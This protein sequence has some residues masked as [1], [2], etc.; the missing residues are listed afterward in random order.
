MDPNV[1]E[2][3]K[4]REEEDEEINDADNDEEN[5]EADGFEQIKEK[6]EK[7]QNQEKSPFQNPLIF[8]KLRINEEVK[9]NDEVPENEEEEKIEE[10]EIDPVDL[11]A[12]YQD[13]DYSGLLLDKKKLYYREGPENYQVALMT[14][15]GKDTYFISNNFPI[16]LFIIRR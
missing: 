7:L 1:E 15:K 16:F 13:E 14:D 10:K 12:K 11:I 6:L 9:E 2:D 5:Q 8:Q 4:D 3:K